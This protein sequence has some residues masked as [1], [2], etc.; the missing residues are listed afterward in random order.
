MIVFINNRKNYD[1]KIKYV[2]VKFKV[3]K[4]YGNQLNYCFYDEDFGED[5]VEEL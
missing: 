2:L 3:V 4:V 1:G 5:I